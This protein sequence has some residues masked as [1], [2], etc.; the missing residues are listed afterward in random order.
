MMLKRKIFKI[1]F[2]TRCSLRL[3]KDMYF[4]TCKN[5]SSVFKRKAGVFGRAIKFETVFITNN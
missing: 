3:K 1:Y 2:L 4:Q 5:S